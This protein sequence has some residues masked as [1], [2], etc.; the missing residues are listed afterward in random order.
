LTGSFTNRDQYRWINQ[1]GVWK[2]ERALESGEKEILPE[3]VIPTSAP[4]RYAEMPSY[5][6]WKR[7]QVSNKKKSEVEEVAAR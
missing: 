4:C 1:H 6:K 2:L 3:G 5:A 7:D